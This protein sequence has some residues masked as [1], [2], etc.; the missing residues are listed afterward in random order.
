VALSQLGIWKWI[1]CMHFFFLMGTMSVCMTFMLSYS[2]C[3]CQLVSSFYWAHFENTWT[4]P[5]TMEYNTLMIL[6]SAHGSWICRASLIWSLLCFI[7]MKNLGYILAMPYQRLELYSLMHTTR[8]WS[9]W[10]LV[11]KWN[12]VGLSASAFDFCQWFS[13]NITWIFWALDSV[14]Y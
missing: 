6:L 13:L 1:G 5:V 12:Y 7:V 2:G 4:T 8:Y 10:I 11:L 9:I 14:V 3:C